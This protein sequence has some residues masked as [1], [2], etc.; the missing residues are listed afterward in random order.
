MKITGYQ[1]PKSS[2]L[3]IDKDMGILTNMILKN[4][5]LK[6]MLHY[7]AKDCLDF[8]KLNEEQSLELFGK[9]IK[10]VPK[11]YID[12]EVLNYIFIKFDGFTLNITNPEFRNNVIE[13]DIVCHYDQWQLRD[14]QLRPYRIAAEL[15]SMFNKQRF[16]G[17]GLL[18]FNG[19]HLININDEYGGICLT[20][21]AIH[22]EEDKKNAPNPVMQEQIVENFND[23]FNT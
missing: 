4:E 13:F 17:I 1:Q 5:N 23:I 3:S 8:P 10:I 9:N 18:E 16:S 12:E 22:G 6:K 11:L 15:D 21:R 20:Y 14:F 19:G 7:T 2:F